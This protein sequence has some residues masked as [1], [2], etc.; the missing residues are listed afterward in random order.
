MRRLALMLALLAA[1][2]AAQDRLVVAAVNA[3]L[4]SFADTLGG[5]GVE[6]LYPVPE[7]ADAALWR[8]PINTISAIQGADIILLNG[9]EFA[10]WTAKVS[11]PRSRT[12]DTS[13]VFSD[14]YIET[15]E[16]LTHSHGNEGAHSHT[17]LVA[18]TWLDFA[19]ARAQADAVA[20]AII[21]KAPAMQPQVAERLVALEG[22]LDALDARARDIG[23]GIAGVPVYAMHPGY[24]YF[25]RAYVPAMERLYWPEG[26]AD[27]G[28]VLG[29]I[30]RVLDGRETGIA[31]W[32]AEPA[33]EDAAWL[34]ERG[35][36]SVVLPIG[37][38]VAG[39]F[40]ARMTAGLD[41]LEAALQ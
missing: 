13:V 19:Q 14:A 23:V 28:A 5:D 38:S 31:L 21:R 34:Q 25:A 29:D 33:A 24:D 36:R 37:D 4:A 11:L 15:A 17:G 41:A 1:P 7:G 8:P 30:A 3:P 12:V 2:V 10:K 20:S 9:A 40:V 35:V 27:R 26:D 39:D 22:E 16:G 6:V 18:T 32:P